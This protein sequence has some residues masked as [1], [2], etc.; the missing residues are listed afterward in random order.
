MSELTP[1]E[2]KVRDT[3]SRLS[4]G[5]GV[6][7]TTVAYALPTLDT[8]PLSS[9]LVDCG[10]LERVGGAVRTADIVPPANAEANARQRLRR[11]Q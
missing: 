2:Q 11:L 3:V 8:T 9:E 4:D 7:P 10:V 5:V 1:H 6:N